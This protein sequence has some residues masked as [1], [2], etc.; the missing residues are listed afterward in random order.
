MLLWVGYKSVEDLSI[1]DPQTDLDWAPLIVAGW[2]TI[3]GLILLGLKL[4]GR[5]SWVAR[6]TDR[7]EEELEEVDDVL[8]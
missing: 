8:Q 6:T 3:G 4:A 7:F 5:D 2:L 1:L